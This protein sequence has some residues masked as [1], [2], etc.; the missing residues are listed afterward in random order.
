MGILEKIEEKTKTTIKVEDEDKESK[1]LILRYIAPPPFLL[2]TELPMH[3][4]IIV[5]PM[6][7]GKTS[8]VKAKIGEAIKLLLE[9]DCV[10]E[11]HIA[12]IHSYERGVSEIVEAARKELDLKNISFLFL[13]N[14]DAPGGSGQHSR[15]TYS[16][17]NVN[18][19]KYYIMIR[20]RL[21]RL[22]YKGYLFVIHT[23]QVYSLL[24]ITFR[25][26]AALKFFKDYPDEPIDLKTLGPMLGSAGMSWLY[27]QSLKLWTPRS[28]D[29]YLEAV[30]SALGKFKKRRVIVHADRN[31][32]LN[33][34]K[35][36]NIVL[37]PKHDE[38]KDRV[39]GEKVKESIYYI[40]K[41]LNKLYEKGVLVFH[42]R[43][44]YIK[45]NGVKVNIGS[46]KHVRKIMELT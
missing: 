30:Y 4:A 28:L 19:S 17:E 10:D 13:F 2:R 45:Y 6:F 25:R 18:E 31:E 39:M 8:F 14:D 21:G 44:A 42:S 38:D 34:H 46:A 20:H 41:K 3:A 9:K 35:V 40:S 5:G 24:D 37:E 23:T 12:F 26:T 11:K 15:K 22:G 43:V 36:R 27:Y 7:S 32:K 33:L 16:E 1:E 29:D